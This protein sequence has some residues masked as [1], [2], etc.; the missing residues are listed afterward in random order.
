MPRPKK[1][2]Y[3]R[4]LVQVPEALYA[5]L[6]VLR[7]AELQD[8]KTGFAKYG[9]FSTYVQRLIRQDLEEIKDELRRA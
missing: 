3:R 6:F 8:A 4:I 5:E 1:P 2:P 9:A 7:R